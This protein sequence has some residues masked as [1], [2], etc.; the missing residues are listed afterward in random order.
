MEKRSILITGGTGILGSWVLAKALERGYAPVV[1]MR[2]ATMDNARERLR[3][4]LALPGCEERLD[5]I[6]IVLGDT[7]QKDLGLSGEQRQFLRDNLDLVIH[8]AASISFN[9][10]KDFELQSANVDGLRHMMSLLDGTNTPLYHVSTAYV[11]G[12]HHGRVMEQD[13][14]DTTCK[15]TYERTKREAE[16]I[17]RAALEAGDVKGAVFRPSVIVGAS[18]DGLISQFHNFYSILRLVD[19]IERGQLPAGESLRLQGNPES[20]LNIAPVDWVAEALWM[21]VEREGA[22]GQTYHL[23][24]PNPCKQ[25]ELNDWAT[26]TLKHVGSQMGFQ[27]RLEGD[28]T[29]AEQAANASLTLYRSYLLDEPI[30]DRSN[31]DRALGEDLPCPRVDADMLDM[32]LA[33]AR[34]QKWVGA[35]GCKLRGLLLDED[36]RGSQ[37]SVERLRRDLAEDLAAVTS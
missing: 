4:V 6:T 2:D 26:R 16:G 18:Q 36:P 34:K 28:V 24:N 30:F 13:L 37:I 15:N 3:A 31:T 29:R 27:S 1:L 19:V 8:C 9:P 33:Y 12:D 32:M 14:L 22:S 10:K 5:E 17:F 7:C 23:T 25:Q 21:I 20:T 11:A 35:F